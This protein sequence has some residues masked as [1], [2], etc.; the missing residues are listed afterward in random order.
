MKV[1][2]TGGTGLVGKALTKRLLADGA[3]VIVLSR[4]QQASKT[5]GMTIIQWDGKSIPSSVGAVDVV[6]NLA[7]AGIL[8]SK[9]TPEYKREILDSRVRGTT[10]ST[11]FI[12]AAA[13]KPQVY[14]SASAVGYYGTSSKA[15]ATESSPPGNDFLAKTSIQW[16]KCAEGAGVRT[17]W[18]R[19]GVVM[20]TEGGAFP[21][22]LKPFK[23]YAG[24]YLGDGNQP[25]PWIH[26]D[27]LVKAFRFAIDNPKIEGPVNLVAPQR[28]NNKQFG[29]IV[30]KLLGKPSGIPVPSFAVKAMLGESALVILEGQLVEPKALLDAGFTFQYEK[31]EA[32]IKELLDRMG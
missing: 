5:A 2:I 18:M 10:A 20:A 9:W 7:G 3:E 16:E 13:V 19:I 25:F 6:I 28:L 27:D 11:Q 32:A 14:I 22:L 4:K 1:M 17:V 30:G 29:Q 21:R 26:I 24:G 15:V 8:D 23:F 12:Q 31:G